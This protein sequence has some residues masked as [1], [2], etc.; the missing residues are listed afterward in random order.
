MK[1]QKW[2]KI[3]TERV[4]D[5]KFFK[6][7]KD[8]VRLP[9]DREI[10][11]FYWDSIDSAMVVA[12]TEEGKAVM[13]EQYR[14]LPN[15]V[16][17]EFPSG[18][19]HEG[20]ALEDCAAREL[21]EETGYGCDEYI[22]LGAFHETMSQLKR[23][24][25]IYYGKGAKPVNERTRTPDN[26]EEGIEQIE[27]VLEGLDKLPDRIMKG[28]LTSMGTSLAVFLANEYR[29]KEKDARTS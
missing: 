23:K 29:R 8:S 13:V 6:V 14:Y 28:E 25:F 16:A 5:H 2:K 4:F 20:E 9:D 26:G 11:W 1:D 17:L 18:G 10:D 12:I 21:E 22:L 27:V 7:N 24:I 15:E 19:S 3:K